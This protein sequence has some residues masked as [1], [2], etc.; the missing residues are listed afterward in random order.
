MGATR[1]GFLKMVVLQVVVGESGERRLSP[2][3]LYPK[4]QQ[5]GEVL[6]H[7]PRKSKKQ[8]RGPRQANNLQRNLENIYKKH[9]FE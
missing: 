3:D 5:K 2:Q 8:V 4:S 7:P 9:S 6:I 1:N